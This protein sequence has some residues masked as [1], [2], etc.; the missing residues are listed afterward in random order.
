MFSL[1]LNQKI[2]NLGISK[3]LSAVLN[4]PYKAKS[5]AELQKQQSAENSLQQLLVHSALAQT[6][7]EVYIKLNLLPQGQ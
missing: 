5:N 6:F 4:V 7:S 1:V 2:P 3:F